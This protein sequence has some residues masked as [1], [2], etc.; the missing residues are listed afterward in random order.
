MSPTLSSVLT[1]LGGVLPGLALAG[2]LLVWQRHALTSARYD[3]THDDTTGLPNRRSLRTHLRA[4]LRNMH[5]VGV[6]RLD[7][8]G[9]K[10]INDGMGR[11]GGDQVLRQVAFRLRAVGSPVGLAAR[12]S[13]DEFVLVIQGGAEETAAVA[14]AAHDAISGRPFRLRRH[15]ID[16]TASVGHA[17]AGQGIN[18][19][20]VL[21]HADLALHAAKAAGSG[22]RAYSDDLDDFPPPDRP[23]PRSR[24]RRHS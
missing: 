8:D 2:L 3:A 21:H 22:V 13:G 19:R 10:D 12:L 15:D 23:K 17:V 5:P 11:D 4:S 24:D 16:V 7:L 20:R 9:F 1:A 6:V 14:W 18:H